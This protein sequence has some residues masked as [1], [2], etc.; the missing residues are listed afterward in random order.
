MKKS[1]LGDY[2]LGLDCNHKT[3]SVKIEILLLNVL[4]ESR[5]QID[6]SAQIYLCDESLKMGVGNFT[7]FELYAD[8]RG[9]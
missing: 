5:F 4:L 7:Q 2:I 9:Q 6:I 8:I 1:S 3:W